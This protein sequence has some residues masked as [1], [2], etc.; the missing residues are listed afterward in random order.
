MGLEK[1]MM[2]GGEELILG[3]SPLQGVEAVAQAPG[4]KDKDRAKRRAVRV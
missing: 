3:V 1:Q 2:G 4:V